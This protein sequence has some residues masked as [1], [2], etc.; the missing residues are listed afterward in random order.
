MVVARAAATAACSWVRREPISISGRPPA[1]DTIL[2][3]AEGDGA[4][5]I[6]DRQ[7]ES[8]Q[9]TFAEGAGRSTGSASPGKNHLGGLSMSPR[10]RKSRVGKRRRVQER[11]HRFQGRVVEDDHPEPPA[12]FRCRR[13]R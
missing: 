11:T 13:C 5:V 3:A 10:N 6:E 8:F 2:A 1:A 12:I 4:V 7:G 9:H